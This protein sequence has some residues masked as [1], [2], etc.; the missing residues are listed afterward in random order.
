MFHGSLGLSATG[1]LKAA[2]HKAEQQLHVPQWSPATAAGISPYPQG[3]R[4]D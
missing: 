1:F 2:L 3:G 4:E